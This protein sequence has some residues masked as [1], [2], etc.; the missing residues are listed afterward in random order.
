MTTVPVTDMPGDY[1]ITTFSE[2][3][4]PSNKHY[5][6]TTGQLSIL[7]TVNDKLLAKTRT[8]AA[9]PD[10]ILVEEPEPEDDEDEDDAE[11]EIVLVEQQRQQR[12]DIMMSELETVLE[13]NERADHR[14]LSMSMPRHTTPSLGTVFDKDK[15]MR[16]LEE[17]V[18]T[19]RKQRAENPP[20]NLENFTKILFGKGSAASQT[21]TDVN[22]RLVIVNYATINNVPLTVEDLDDCSEEE[23]TR[24]YTTIKRY[25][26]SRK[27]KVI[28]TNMIIVIVNVLEH[29]LVRLGFD[30]AR[31]MSADVTTEI[32]D[33]EIGEDCEAIA[34]SMGICNNPVLNILLF[35]VKIL[36]RR[37]NVV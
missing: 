10:D 27:R 33:L 34:S 16:L 18:A 2:D 5:E 8:R 31:G 37:V 9:S 23:I 22:R 19:L 21:V 1:T 28:V 3:D 14:P 25:H 6:I 24:M 35:M 20:G 13:E 12:F 4:Y 29:V 32:I 26:E 15:R 30:G 11:E 7:R 36:I 17:E